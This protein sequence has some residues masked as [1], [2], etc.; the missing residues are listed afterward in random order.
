M[1]KKQKQKSIAGAITAFLL[2]VLFVLMNIAAIPH[3]DLVSERY[4]EINWMRFTPRPV[5]V[6]KPDEPKKGRESP[7]KI[8]VAEPLISRVDLSQLERQLDLSDLAL[9]TQSIAPAGKTAKAATPVA[10]QTS[11]ID[12][13]G[14]S[15]F[16][17]ALDEQSPLKQL[18]GQR[19]G[20]GGSGNI[21][22]QAGEGSSAGVGLGDFGGDTG[23]KLSGPRSVG[24]NSASGEIDLQEL[25]QLEEEFADFSPLYRP[26]IEWMKRHPA[27]LPPV[28]KRFM[29]HKPGDLTSWVQFSIQK[30]EFEM[31]LLCVEET[32]E[33]RIVLVERKQVIY[34]IDQGFREQSNFLRTGRLNRLDSGEILKFGTN[35][36]PA[37][38]GKTREFYQIFMSWWES[39]KHEVE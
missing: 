23:A 13:S 15:D 35:L 36:E 4:D 6:K 12:L 19:Q 5:R 2:L 25:A 3:R 33:V 7:Q 10:S 30:R 8:A 18:P 20:G 28:V 14:F 24:A 1:S 38:S 32:Y 26:L 17:L 27:T 22:L 11:K 39:V 9:Q 21:E 31:F 29:S 37:G 34:L 16:N